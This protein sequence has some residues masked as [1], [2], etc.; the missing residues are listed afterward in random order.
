MNALQLL[1]VLLISAAGVLSETVPFSRDVMK[2]ATKIEENL[3]KIKALECR[4]ER[5]IPRKFEPHCKDFLQEY[6]LT[7]K[8]CFC[9]HKKVSSNDH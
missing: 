8:D 1:F 5:M 4:N 3:L 9:H 7:Y 2:L 6:E